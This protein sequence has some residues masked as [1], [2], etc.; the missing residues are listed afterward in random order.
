MNILAHIAPQRA[1]TVIRP[2]PHGERACRGGV[3]VGEDICKKGYAG[4]LCA[5]CEHGHFY[6]AGSCEDCDHTED[7]GTIHEWHLRRPLVAASLLGLG[8]DI[9]ALQEPSPV[10]AEQL[11]QDLGA[12]W[13]VAVT[14]PAVSASEAR[15]V[16]A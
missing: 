14:T 16:C 10:Q 15:L 4:A 7:V 11:E 2:C 3:E 12:E 9:V 6:V 1:V 5:T 13:G 8:A